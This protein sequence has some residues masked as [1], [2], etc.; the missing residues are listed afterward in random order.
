M[1][2]ISALFGGADTGPSK[3][4]QQALEAREKKVAAQERA[5][6]AEKEAALRARRGRNASLLSG[7]TT[8]AETEQERRKQVG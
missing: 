6:K 5:R 8:G 4:Q 1:S 7:L 3:K 2:K